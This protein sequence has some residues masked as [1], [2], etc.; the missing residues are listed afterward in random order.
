MIYVVETDQRKGQVEGEKGRI[1]VNM[2][3]EMGEKA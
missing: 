2:R 1:R 3:Q